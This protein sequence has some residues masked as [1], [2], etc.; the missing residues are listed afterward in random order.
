[1]LK[2]EKLFDN[3]IN[4]VY[5]KEGYY[6]I[7]S[8]VF[9]DHF[10][11]SMFNYLNKELNI[12]IGLLLL[13]KYFISRLIKKSILKISTFNIYI[14]NFKNKTQHTLVILNAFFILLFLLALLN[15]TF[16]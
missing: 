2:L 9:V 1:M 5:S 13:D 14:I 11:K 15:Y 12:F 3:I 6:A 10:F 7:K 8:G 4:F 16:F